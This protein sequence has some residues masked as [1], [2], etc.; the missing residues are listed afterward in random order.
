MRIW[1]SARREIEMTDQL[2]DR[3]QEIVDRV[4]SALAQ[5]SVTVRPVEVHTLEGGVSATLRFTVDD[6]SSSDLRRE[7]IAGSGESTEA[8]S[9]E[10]LRDL[11]QQMGMAAA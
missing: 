4:V 3:E 10:V 5:H 8:L 11:L 7:R 1:L 6:F 9:N 2:T